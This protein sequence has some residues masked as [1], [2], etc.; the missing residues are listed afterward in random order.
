MSTRRAIHTR[1]IACTGYQ[2]DDGLWDIEGELTDTRGLPLVLL[3]K[4][5]APGEPLHQMRLVMTVDDDLVIRSVEARTDAGPTR[6]CAEI[7]EAYRALEGIAIGRGFLAKV[8]QLFA[9]AKGCTHLTDLIGPMATTAMQAQWA[10]RSHRDAELGTNDSWEAKRPWIVDSCHAYR[11][12]GEIVK[13]QW[14]EHYKDDRS[15]AA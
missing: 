6:V 11:E 1:H 7:N 2:R 14:P 15:S 12:G 13:L 5:L 9:G 4:T 3:H 10:V 8:R